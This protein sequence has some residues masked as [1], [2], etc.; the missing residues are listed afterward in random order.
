[1]SSQ[2]LTLAQIKQGTGFDR[3]AKFVQVPT[4]S[5]EITPIKTTSYRLLSTEEALATCD[6]IVQASQWFQIEPLPDDEWS[7][8]LKAEFN[9]EAIENRLGRELE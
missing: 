1:M 2:I 8:T 6:E 3:D 7:L 9:P 5:G 4:V